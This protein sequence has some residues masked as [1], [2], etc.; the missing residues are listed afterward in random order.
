MAGYGNPEREG[1]VDMDRIYD[2]PR[3]VQYV[4]DGNWP[5]MDTPD[6]PRLFS[7]GEDLVSFQDEADLVERWANL[8]PE[9]FELATFNL[10]LGS[11][12]TGL[13]MIRDVTRE[14]SNR[15]ERA[16]KLDE[17]LRDIGHQAAEHGNNTK[18]AG[19]GR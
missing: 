4:G 9:E 6:L 13:D 15:I 2:E 3:T 18:E 7:R 10:S 8:T 11:L 19:L 16:I 5:A 17:R 1:G 14:L 12:R